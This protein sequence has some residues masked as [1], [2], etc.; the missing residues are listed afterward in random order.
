MLRRHLVTRYDTLRDLALQYMGSADRWMEIAAAN[1]L[2]SADLAASIG[3]EITIPVEAPGVG[4]DP[5]KVDL[6]IRDG[7]LAATATGDLVTIGGRQN[8][9]I[10]II[11]MFNTDPGELRQHPSK[12]LDVVGYQGEAIVGL[13]GALIR[14]DVDRIFKADPRTSRILKNAA[15]FLPLQKRVSISA[16]VEDVGGDVT[17]FNEDVTF[18]N[19]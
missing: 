1:G 14:L 2:K 15:T 10:S 9:A 16:T 7:D 11:R 19:G 17:H 5:Y 6:L 3:K 13:A 12:G 18:P 4:V 8:Y